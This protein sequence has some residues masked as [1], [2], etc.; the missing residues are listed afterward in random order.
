MSQRIHNQL[1]VVRGGFEF[2]IPFGEDEPTTMAHPT[3]GDSWMDCTLSLVIRRV[4]RARS[5]SGR[6]HWLGMTRPAA[7]GRA[8]LS[9]GKQSQAGGWHEFERDDDETPRS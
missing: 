9:A 5:D 1:G 6:D 4:K 2:K 8:E 3:A 7:R